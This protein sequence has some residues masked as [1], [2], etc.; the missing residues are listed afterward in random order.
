MTL[1]RKAAT[2]AVAAFLAVAAAF[3]AD[4]PTGV[5]SDA[6]QAHLDGADA[7]LGANVYA[8][9]SLNTNPGG[10]LRMRVGTGQLFMMASTDA[11]LTQDHGR[12]DMLIKSGTAGLSATIDDPLEIDTP[13]GTV[14]PANTQRAFGQVTITS[15]T[16]IIITSYE[17]TLSLT[18]GTETHLIEAGKS[19]RV[20]LAP[21]PAP[22]P[23]PQGRQGAGR[24]NHDQLIFDLIVLGGAA[25]GGYLVWHYIC[26]SPSVP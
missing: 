17:G 4:V 1:C 24:S 3:A 9:D 2:A 25:A 12:I 19:Y 18:R 8:G 14:R 20:T 26:E 22:P 15:P 5:I 23:E 7:A 11:S 16:Q 13:I 10:T 6:V 21:T